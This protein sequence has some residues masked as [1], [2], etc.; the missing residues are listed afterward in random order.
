MS[1]PMNSMDESISETEGRFRHLIDSVPL[2]IFVSDA[3][4]NGVYFNREWL[5]FTGHSFENLSGHRWIDDL[6]PDDRVECM[7]QFNAALGVQESF[8]FECRLRRYDGDYHHVL[9]I[10]VPDFAGDGRF[11]GYIDTAVDVNNQKAAEEALRYSEMR[12]D[13]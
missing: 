7:E 5:A 13:A 1:M 2:L 8:S 10:G 4:G 12:C 9:N 6:H 3:A 11:L